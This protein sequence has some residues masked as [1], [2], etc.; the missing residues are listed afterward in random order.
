MTDAG[1]PRR[2]LQR[3]I[4]IAQMRSGVEK[5]PNFRV[6]MKQQSGP[7]VKFVVENFISCYIV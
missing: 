7:V 5:L 2:M 3:E 6:S 1:G 4:S